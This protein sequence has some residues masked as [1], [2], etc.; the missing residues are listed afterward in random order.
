MGGGGG[1][2]PNTRT[3][4]DIPAEFKP[5]YLQLFNSAYAASRT[6]AGQPGY[7]QGLPT[8]TAEIPTPLATV[9]MAA[10][11]YPR[12]R[13]LSSQMAHTGQRI[14]AGPSCLR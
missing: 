11:V 3:I 13:C 6:A 12:S 10:M 5:A 4:Q 7:G 2:D 8:S 1:S 9:G 14:R